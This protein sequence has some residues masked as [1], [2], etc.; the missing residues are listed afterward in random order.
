[1]LSALLIIPFL[2]LGQDPVESDSIA[3][4]IQQAQKNT[5]KEPAL[6]AT[7]ADK[8]LQMAKAENRMTEQGEAFR[9]IGGSYYLRGDYDLAL[10][11]FLEAYQIFEQQLDTPKI[12]RVLSNLGLVYKSLEDY[13]KSLEYY[14]ISLGLTDPGDSV[15]LSKIYNNIGVVHKRKANYDSAEYYFNRSLEIKEGLGDA[16]GVANTLTNLGNI[17]AARGDNAKAIAFFHRS[18]QLERQLEHDEGIAKNMNNMAG[19]HLLMNQ[20]DSA[21]YYALIGYEI[22]QKLK[23]KL[24]IKESTEILAACY[25]AKKK[26]A[27][28]YNYQQ[29]YIQYKDSLSS[30]DQSRKIGRLESKLELAK[31][32]SEIDQL[33]LA[34]QL[35]AI[36]LKASRNQIIWISILC[37]TILVAAV[38]IYV[39]R[40]RAYKTEKLAQMSQLEALQKRYL[41][42]IEGPSTFKLT[43]SLDQLNERL[44][45]PLT[46]REYETL[47]ASLKGLTNQQIADALFVSLSTVKFHLGNV[48]NKF[49]VNNKKEAL[50]YVVKTS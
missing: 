5:Y 18:L 1:M 50:E 31:Q 17:V 12:T 27:Q 11:N 25:A 40:A 29:I 22:G 15:T 7:M 48:Y 36:N 9:I 10:D 42:L 37:V 38:V 19:S 41:E 14:R 21:I 45:N 26:Y 8:A 20:V 49:G 47:Q 3:I 34:N 46:E 28:A 24:Q 35:Q 16:K 2:S 32:Q 23:T 13:E 4:L 43:L 33:T 6:A 30:E 39:F 44:V